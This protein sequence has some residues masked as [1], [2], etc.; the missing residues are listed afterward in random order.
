MCARRDRPDKGDAAARPPMPGT[1]GVPAL[2]RIRQK[3]RLAQLLGQTARSSGQQRLRGN[4]SV[5][6]QQNA[7]PIGPYSALCPGMHTAARHG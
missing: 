4:P 5:E 6:R 3:I 1:F 2:E 7:V